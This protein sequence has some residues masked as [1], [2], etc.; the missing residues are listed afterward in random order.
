MKTLVVMN[1]KGG[2]GKTNLVAHGGW[3]FAEQ[4][5]TLVIDLDQQGNL[6]AT[7]AKDLAKESA[8]TLFQ[9]GGRIRPVGALTVAGASRALS[10][11]EQTAEADG[12]LAFRDNLAAMADDY[13]VCLID[14]PPAL[15]NRTF[16]ALLASDAVL[17]PIGVN[18]YSLAGVAQLLKAIKGVSDHFERTPPEF[19]G[20]IPSIYDRKSVR[21]RQLFE[22]LAGEVGQL[23]FPGIVPKRDVYSRAAG[24][25]V[26]VWHMP[27]TSATRDAKAEIWAVFDTVADK[28]GVGRND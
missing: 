3:Y 20:L 16:A 10:D 7:M 8:V 12:I 26:P 18:D 28:M 15:A 21:E 22:A 9:A 17:A 5:R 27:S 25:G 2:V 23:L 24:E 14:T 19:L 6:S 4:R 1:E 11:L 13:D